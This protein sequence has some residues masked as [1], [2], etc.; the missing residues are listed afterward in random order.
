MPQDNRRIRQSLP[1]PREPHSSVVARRVS[2][3]LILAVLAAPWSRAWAVGAVCQVSS[4]A[5]LYCECTEFCGY[6][7]GDIEGVCVLLS[8]GNRDGQRCTSSGSAGNG[9]CAEATCCYTCRDVN[10]GAC[11]ANAASCLPGICQTAATACNGGTYGRD[12]AFGKKADGTNCGTNQYCFTGTCKSGCLIG[13]V[14]YADGA[15]APGNPCQMCQSSVNPS[16]WTNTNEAGSCGGGKYCHTGVCQSGCSISGAFYTPNQLN[17]LN[18]CQRCDPVTNS[19]AWTAYNPCVS[20]GPCQ[21]T[22]GTC[23]PPSGKCTYALAPDSTSCNDGNACTSGESCHSG[24]CTAG[25]TVTCTALDQCHAVGVCNVTTGI[26]SNPNKGD[27]TTCNDSSFCT[28]GETCRSGVCAAATTVTCTAL[29]QCH[30]IGICNA[31]TGICTNPNKSDGS[32]CNDQRSCTSGETCKAGVCTPPTI[33]CACAA[34]SDCPSPDPCH[35]AGICDRPTGSCNYPN[36]PNGTACN[37]NSLCTSGETCRAGVC[38]AATTVVCTSLDQC[39]DVGICNPA[40]GI[41]SNPPKAE[42]AA[43]DDHRSC[44]QGDSC[45]SGACIPT[46]NSCGCRTVLDCPPPGNCESGV[47]CDAVAGTCNYQNK[48][49]GTSCSDGSL[50]TP[51]QDKCLAGVCTGST[52]VTCTAIDSCH[53][54]GS[55]IPSNGAC[56]SP[57]KGDGTACDDGRSC[58][59]GDACLSGAC[60]SQT[61]SCACSVDADCPLPDACHLHAWCDVPSGTCHF[62]NKPDDTPCD[63]GSL[64]TSGET[65]VG[66]VCVPATTVTCTPL[67]QCHDVG[68]CDRKTGVCSNPDKTE[69]AQCDDARPCT[70]GDVCRVGT[71]APAADECHCA[72]DADCAPPDQCHQAA[73]C[74]AGKGICNYPNRADGTGCDDR[75]ACTSGDTCQAGLCIAAS[76]VTCTAKDQ[77]YDE[78]SCDPQIGACSNPNKLDGSICNDGRSCTLDDNCQDGVCSGKASNCA[79]KSSGDCPP[80]QPCHLAGVCDTAA[81]TC[82]YQQAVDGTPCDDGNECTAGERCIAGECSFTTKVTCNDPPQCH[83]ATSC[84]PRTGQCPDPLPSDDRA[85]CDDGNPCTESE[86]CTGG[87]CEGRPVADGTSCP[88]G[89]CH[90]GQCTSNAPGSSPS[91]AVGHYSCGSGGGAGFVGWAALAWLALAIRRR[92]QGVTLILIVATA[93]AASSAQAQTNTG[94]PAQ[95]SP[96]PKSARPPKKAPAPGDRSRSGPRPTD[97]ARATSKTAAKAKK[98]KKSKITAAPVESPPPEPAV[99]AVTPMPAPPDMTFAPAATGPALLSGG[100]TAPVSATGPSAAID[101]S[102]PKTKPPKLAFLGVSGAGVPRETSDSVAEYIQSQLQALGAYEVIGRGEI[103]TL[104]G[105]DREKALLGCSEESCLAEISGALAAER[106]LSGTLSLVGDSYL[107]NL[108]LLDSKKSRV[109]S[110]VGRRVVGTGTIDP[111]LDMIRPA[112]LELVEADPRHGAISTRQV[113]EERGF[114]GLLVAVFGAADVL[115]GVTGGLTTEYSGKRFGVAATVL[116]ARPSPAARLEVRFYPLVLNRVRFYLAPGAALIAPALAAH[117]GLGAQVRLGHIQLLADGGYERFLNNKAVNTKYYR[118]DSVLIGAGL[119]WLF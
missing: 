115:G 14:A 89:Q 18:G 106:V 84:D 63:D 88:S 78:G 55:C 102:A 16:G 38:A 10:R 66:G 77:C 56:S 108:S 37:D 32:A 47:T 41:C 58:T 31:T 81:G 36:K 64:C 34:D 20:P 22:P 114:G 97:S 68:A 19:A 71:C 25:S 11:V 109:I 26:C 54:A 53:D 23:N 2:A 28:S 73:T 17:P 3:M 90:S 79:C 69:G 103:K 27:G 65:C 74:D 35:L 107:I 49:D 9:V 99:E 4:H 57:A 29:D 1:G 93:L 40:T 111:L 118:P 59:T 119:G 44:T 80:A 98:P 60:R 85:S 21:A 7:A 39:H 6:D 52:T 96:E 92:G 62:P 83:D 45:I 95:T 101:S 70:V 82:S 51:G 75:N 100:L 86:A 87:R 116:M 61:S 72:K 112:L 46:T 104:L 94:T 110:R 105:Y 30:N 76:S 33:S 50:C 12:C 117:I 5:D 67:D 113:Q 48:V 8:S 43:C 15:P 24:V 13:G 91:N 42:G